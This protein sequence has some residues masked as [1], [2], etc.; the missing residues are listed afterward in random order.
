MD[1]LIAAPLANPNGLIHA[2]QVYVV[3]GQPPE[4]VISPQTT[5]KRKTN[6]AQGGAELESPPIPLKPP[7]LPNAKAK[8]SQEP[9]FHLER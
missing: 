9:L 5:A 7:V 1:F 2:G 8:P 3:F 4:S 6:K